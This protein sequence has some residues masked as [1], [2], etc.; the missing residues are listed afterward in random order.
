[1]RGIVTPVAASKEVKRP[2]KYIGHLLSRRSH[3][4]MVNADCPD[5]VKQDGDT[6]RLQQYKSIFST[7]LFCFVFIHMYAI[8][9][10]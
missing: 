6:I 2:C 9:L 7:F 10:P 8:Y 4:W 5:S 3:G 1:M